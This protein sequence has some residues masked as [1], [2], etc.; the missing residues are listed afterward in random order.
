MKFFLSTKEFNFYFKKIFV[1]LHVPC[2]RAGYSTN[3]SEDGD[4]WTGI[5]LD[6][7]NE[8]SFEKYDY[9][10]IINFILFGFGISITKLL[11]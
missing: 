7:K 3:V 5:K 11:I 2:L 8:I 6:I 10:I 1:T 9:G 4:T